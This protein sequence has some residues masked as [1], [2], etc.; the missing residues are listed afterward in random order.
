MV[1]PTVGPALA[2]DCDSR[3]VAATVSF[4]TSSVS[5]A[6]ASLSAGTPID[7]TFR[8]VGFVPRLA[9]RGLAGLGRSILPV[10][11]ARHKYDKCI[12]RRQ[13]SQ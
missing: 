1:S 3:D 8:A 9:G 13:P 11:T 5:I 6:G 7:A 12:P 10:M 4:M 2:G